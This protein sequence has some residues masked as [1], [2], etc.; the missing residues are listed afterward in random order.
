MSGLYCFKLGNALV[1]RLLE[2]GIEGRPAASETESR[3]KMNFPLEKVLGAAM[4]KAITA[5]QTDGGALHDCLTGQALGPG[6]WPHSSCAGVWI[7][8]LQEAKAA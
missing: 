8:R 7:A 5:A 4:K 3:N 6:P 1:T 2:C